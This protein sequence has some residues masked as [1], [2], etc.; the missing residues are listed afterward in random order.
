MAQD[1][2]DD[3]DFAAGI[4]P[5]AAPTHLSPVKREFK[6]WHKPRKHWLRLNQW[7]VEARKLIEQLGSRHKEKVLTYLTLPGT[8]MLDVRIMCDVCEKHGY[9]VK[10]LGFNDPGEVANNHQLELNISES[11]LAKSGAV[12]PESFVV[13]DKFEALANNAKVA[14]QKMADFGSFDVVNLDL[15]NSMAGYVPL[16]QQETYFDALAKLIEFQ[17]QNR[18]NPW[19]LFITTRVDRK[20]IKAE[21]L[22]SLLSCISQNI[23]NHQSFHEEIKKGFKLDGTI[24]KN[25][26]NG[27]R[28][29]AQQ[30][31]DG[32][33]IGLGKWL[34]QYL[35]SGQPKWTLEMLPSWCYTVN[36]ANQVADMVSFA[37][38]CAPIRER[39]VDRSRLSSP[40][41][42]SAEMEPVSELKA[43]LALLKTL[44]EMQNID[45]QLEADRPEMD[46]LIKLAAQLMARARYDET[47]YMEEFGLGAVVTAKRRANR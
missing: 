19:L 5:S 15:C 31:Y 25:G 42:V 20:T 7:A 26:I 13:T 40:R 1:P 8:D 11:E 43:A 22:S 2:N 32:F 21:A 14:Y 37:F 46:N 34:L 6:P 4:G 30:L 44:K 10:Y 35:G 47:A 3:A 9:K 18:V 24:V 41:G 27:Q 29:S 12:H 33:S 28:L 45:A 39:K 38:K 23:A 17:A 16:Q 36:P